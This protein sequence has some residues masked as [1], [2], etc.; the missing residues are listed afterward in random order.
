MKYALAW[1]MGACCGFGAG[2]LITAYA[3]MK[4]EELERLMKSDFPHGPLCFCND[5]YVERTRESHQSQIISARLYGK[6]HESN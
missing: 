1:I 3:H 5:C 2:M 4:K 6:R